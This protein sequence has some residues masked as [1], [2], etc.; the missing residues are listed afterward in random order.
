MREIEM[1]FNEGRAAF[2]DQPSLSYGSFS[3]IIVLF[4]G[5]AKYA[6]IK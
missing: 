6:N 2:Y 5:Q 3:K 1:R 4:F